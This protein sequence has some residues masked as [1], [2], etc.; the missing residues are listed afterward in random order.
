MKIQNGFRASLQQAGW[1][2]ICKVHIRIALTCSFMKDGA[3]EVQ[4]QSFLTS[5][6]MEVSGHLTPRRLYARKKKNPKAPT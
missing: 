6:W 2:K 3:V 5:H 1:D 4:F